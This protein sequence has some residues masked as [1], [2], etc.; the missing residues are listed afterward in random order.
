LYSSKNVH[1]GK[2]LRCDSV[3]KILID[4]GAHLTIGDEVELRRNLEI[5]VHQQ[6]RI[7]IGSKVR[8]DRGV[9]LLATNTAQLNIADGVRIGLYT[10]FNGGDSI[11]VGA[12]TLISGFVYL[13]T[14]MHGFKNK[15]VAIQQQGYAHAP[16]C[17]KEDVW[18]GTH[19]VVLP[20]VTLERGVVV[21]SNAVVTKSVEANAVIGGIPAKILKERT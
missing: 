17:L 15:E 16:V 18:L 7:T 12:G 19:V 9:R 2:N 4:K 11:E 8:I 20:G 3:P 1:F 10:V 5:R 14:S 6:A 13:Q 21:G